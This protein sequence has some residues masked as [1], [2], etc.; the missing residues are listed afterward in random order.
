MS[1]D[2]V[3]VTGVPAEVRE[4][5]AALA[6]PVPALLDRR[7]SIAVAGRPK[8]GRGRS[9]ILQPA[10]RK[11]LRHRMLL[12]R[13]ASLERIVE[14]TGVSDAELKRFRQELVAS[15][16]PDLLIQRGAAGAFVEELPQGA[17]LYLMVRALRPDR[18]V[19]TGVRPGYS[20]A[21]ILAALEA[22][23][24]GELTS[25]GPGSAVGRV[26]GV[27]EVSVGQFVPPAL[28]ARWTLVLGNTP[29][30]VEATL[31]SSPADLVFSDNGPSV[32]RARAEFKV[33]W[34]ALSP[35]GVLLAHHIDANPAWDELCQ[36]QGL[37]R[38]V[39]DAGPPPMGALAIRPA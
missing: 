12:F 13:S 19:E 7:G 37:S 22:N 30:S 34:G 25:L 16:L 9:P 8:N 33:A 38:Q 2:R 20:T 14:L 11:Q 18:V 29:E 31:A 35:R 23:G 10:V 39:F 17:L 21:W 27:H 24:A 6:P 26:P 4:D 5:A 15:E 28:R 1:S 32:E 3:F 36:R